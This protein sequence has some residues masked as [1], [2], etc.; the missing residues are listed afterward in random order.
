MNPPNTAHEVF[1]CHSSKDRAT[2]NSV[3]ATLERSGV[4]CWMAPRDVIP[5]IPYAEAIADGIGK[6]RLL[7]LI[8][9]A[10]AN[11]SNHVMRE[12]EVAVSQGI[13]VLPFRIE[14]V[15]PSKALSYFVQAVHWL[16]A[17]TP[18]PDRRLAELVASVRAILQQP[19][20][21]TPTALVRGTSPAAAGQLDPRSAEPC[22]ARPS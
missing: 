8:L 14:E 5:G 11:K 9:S 13:P 17:F 6:G 7:V 15:E 20:L 12:V 2:A 10:N 16:D 19:F 18:P 4:R 21:R 3:C 1:I 22:R